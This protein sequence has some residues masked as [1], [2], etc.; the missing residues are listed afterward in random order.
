MEVILKERETNQISENLKIQDCESKIDSDNDGESDESNLLTEEASS[1][2][3]E[4]RFAYL[5]SGCNK[6]VLNSQEVFS[7]LR[8]ERKELTT[9]RR[10]ATLVI[11]EGG[12]A[13]IYNDVY[14]SQNAKRNLVGVWNVIQSDF[15]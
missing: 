11:D 4:S 9:A 1:L 12:S 14:D 3:E 2:T 15:W 6:V 5:D 8:T 13:G 10:G 7:H